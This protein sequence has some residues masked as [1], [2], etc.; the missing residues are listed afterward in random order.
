MVILFAILLFSVLIFLHELGHFVAAKLSK[1][2]V[3]E[4]A[5][6]MGPA[7][8]KWK[9]GET[10][11]S[12]RCI[13]IGGY[14]AMEGEN[15]DTD[16][17]GSFQKASWWKRLIILFAGSGMN[18]ITGFLLFAIFLS[19]NA[20]ITT[21]EIADVE[22]RQI[23]A[24]ADG[25]QAGDIILSV[26]GI[27]FT[28]ENGAELKDQLLDG[29]DHDVVVFRAAEEVTLND[30][31]ITTVD[32]F[33]TENGIRAGDTWSEINGENV[34]VANNFNSLVAINGNQLFDF[35]FQRDGEEITIN[36]ARLENALFIDSGVV[37]M[38]YGFA[39]RVE[40]TTFG[41]VICYAWDNCVAAVR[42]V[43]LS[44]QMLFTGQA[45]VKDVSGPVG[46]VQMMSES[47]ES[48][49][50]AGTA[51]N[52]LLYFGAFIAVNLAVMN[53]LPIPALD[54]GR[55]FGLLVITVIEAITKK[56]VNPKVE[57]YIHGAGMI[58]L[59]L[60]MVLVMFKDI[61]GIFAG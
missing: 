4:F 53:L 11:Y 42:D 24:T 51:V 7:L 35:V 33:W 61:W 15:E 60:L 2:R 43:R 58:L 23:V 21:P 22:S 45:S 52:N 20:G 1:V 16:D 44:L 56:K 28:K 19:Q 6:F 25:L 49:E 18:F 37:K 47:V 29:S 36:D 5:I 32:T 41:N 46:I 17:P 27:A 38:R 8:I 39:F 48:A 57:A 40:K 31:V 12:I 3:N 54:G 55:I 30:L 14:C 10:Q 34:Y 59:L 13:P 26:D 50:D 9:R